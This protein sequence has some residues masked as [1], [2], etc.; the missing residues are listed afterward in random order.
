MKPQAY[1]FLLA[2]C[3]WSV[4]GLPMMGHAEEDPAKITLDKAVHFTAPNGDDLLIPAG[5]Y[6]V[7]GDQDT[8][9][10]TSS[11]QEA[12][13][14]IA[15][16]RASHDQPLDF[17]VAIAIPGGEEAP[18]GLFL[19]LLLPDRTSLEA[20]GS[21]SGV[22][23]RGGKDETQQFREGIGNALRNVSEKIPSIVVLEKA[24]HFTAPDGNDLLA[25]PGTYAVAGE[26]ERIRLLREN[27]V[28]ALVIEAYRGSHDYGVELPVAVSI[29]GEGEDADAVFIG[30]LSPD[31]TSLE[32]IGSYSG[33]RGR[34]LRDRAEQIREK[35]KQAAAN[36]VAFAQ[37]KARE[38]AVHV[39]KVALRARP[40]AQRLLVPVKTQAAPILQD[41]QFKQLAQTAIQT[42]LRE[43]ADVIRM[44]LDHARVLADPRNRALIKDLMGGERLC[45]RPFQQT[46]A[47]LARMYQSQP[48]PRSVLPTGISWTF[49]LNGEAEYFAGIQ[50]AIGVVT[51]TL[52]VGLIPD[53]RNGRV[54]WSVGGTVVTDVGA[55][56]GVTAGISFEPPPDGIEN[57]FDLAVKGGGDTA[58]GPGVGIQISLAWNPIRQEWKNKRLQSLVP[59]VSG[60]AVGV[61]ASAS[62]SPANIGLDIG[63]SRVT[64]FAW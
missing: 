42:I 43:K 32:A 50:G 12:A 21:F 23:G 63:Y 15:A 57:N 4:L 31:R 64:R 45:E 33:V 9:R 30:L 47:A 40:V 55:S 24:V 37:Q 26:G 51:G 52:P 28:V 25:Q 49:A 2:I 22:R 14:V 11:N 54:Y 58:I 59:Y 62:A 61:S 34:G 17:A 29:P 13:M 36:A 6:A 60:I 10:L 41:P 56:G 38:A 44:L 46:S 20:T 5:I 8:I 1:L 7:A 19:G 3:L 27:Q 16:Q 39:C 53:P 48:Q 35:A 18:D